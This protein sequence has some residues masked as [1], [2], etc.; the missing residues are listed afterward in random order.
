MNDYLIDEAADGQKPDLKSLNSG[1]LDR[2][3]EEGIPSPK[4]G[5]QSPDDNLKDL[6]ERIQENR[7]DDSEADLSVE[8]EK[9]RQPLESLPQGSEI[10]SPLS[11][12][13]KPAKKGKEDSPPTA[14]V[15][16]DDLGGEAALHQEGCRR[17]P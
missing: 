6:L 4:N 7:A 10:A 14:A 1:D 9:P 16:S 8:L 11:R 2:S 13:D 3:D 12:A 17:R 15:R 5:E